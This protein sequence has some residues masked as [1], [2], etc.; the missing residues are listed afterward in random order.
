M[1][2][3]VPSDEARRLIEVDNLVTAGPLGDSGMDALVQLACDFFHVPICAISLVGQERQWFKASVGLDLTETEREYAFCSFT[4]AGTKPVVV[5]DASED[6]RFCRNPLVTGA[7]GIRFYAGVPLALSAGV[8]VGS[9]CIIDRQPKLID[10]EQIKRLDWFGKIAVSLLRQT[11]TMRQVSALSENLSQ[12]QNVC[13]LQ[14]DAIRRQ[15]EMFDRA[16]VLT[17]LGAWEVDLQ[18][19][20][21]SWSEG[22]YALHDVD[23]S[24]DFQSD[25]FLQF[26][27]EPDRSRL[28]ELMDA[29]RRESSPY[30]FEGRMFTAKGRFRWV[31]IVGDVEMEGNV[32][33]R[34]FGLW[35]DISDEKSF[36]DQIQDQARRD[37]LTGLFNRRAMHEELAKLSQAESAP[38]ALGLLSLNLDEFKGVNE[39]H[40]SGA[41]DFCL[42][43]VS[44]RIHIAVGDASIVARTG[45]DEFAILVR[46]EDAETSIDEI[47]SRV[48]AAVASPLQWK[49]H[50]FQLTASIGTAVRSTAEDLVPDDLISEAHLGLR[51][52]KA[53]GGNCYKPFH[54]KLQAVSKARIDTLRDIRRALAMRHLELYYQPKVSLADE[55]HQG[56]EALLRWNKSAASVV[57][58][59]MFLAALEDPILSRDIGDFV[60]AS[61]IAQ[62]DK[63]KRAGVDFGHI[64]VNLS[65]SQF[66]ETDIAAKLF[67]SLTE[68]GLDPSAIEV[69]VTENILLSDAS[70]NV[71]QACKAFRSG[72]V[73]IAF[74]DFGTGYA[75][76]SHLRDFPVDVIKI[77][78]SF[79]SQLYQ[80]ENTTVI[81]NSIV[82]LAHSLS[83]EVVA[84]GVELESQANFLKA[85]GC[86]QGQG[87]LFGRPVPA[88]VAVSSHNSRKAAG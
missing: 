87:Y 6:E 45:G 28:V 81:V 21:V 15:Q 71:L 33:V 29:S 60:I 49:E 75:S 23:H 66:Q 36:V 7:P 65:A 54:P 20:K 61:A 30:K 24:F 78:R 56:F 4:I 1:E 47:A 62:A 26:Y 19:G 17:K 48:R 16:S 9:F 13:S 88:S 69:E 86:D 55:S 80:G 50:S 18:T 8:N 35:Q 39:S 2:H 83:M 72:G 42:K 76:L 79:V 64:A 31:R 67:A 68:Y 63:W 84:E 57:G 43:S 34:R 5:P 82:G 46:D 41:G 27:P 25:K 74:D 12:Q 73:K 37:D 11:K 85:I 10:N 38:G 58:P 52:A 53:A 32:P 14:G 51:A 77:D 22:M 44:R 3:Q 70:G 59:G 40:G